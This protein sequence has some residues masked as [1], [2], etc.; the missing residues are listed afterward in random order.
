MSTVSGKVELLVILARGFTRLGAPPLEMKRE[1]AVESGDIM[2]RHLKGNT[3]KLI[4]L[5]TPTHPPSYIPI[6]IG[7]QA[8]NLGDTLK[9]FLSFRT[10]MLLFIK[11]SPFHLLGTYSAF[12]AS[13]LFPQYWPLLPPIFP[14][15]N[16]PHGYSTSSL[17]TLEILLAKPGDNQKKGRGSGCVA[18]LNF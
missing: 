14:I 18:R 17:V 10:H 5:L 8:R 1:W 16:N 9:F 15:L 2:F 11:S 13:C 4:H 3:P 12:F 6:S 7:A